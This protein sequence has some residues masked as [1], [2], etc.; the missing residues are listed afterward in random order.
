MK[1]VTRYETSESVTSWLSG[2]DELV[3]CVRAAQ[4]GSSRSEGSE[5][6]DPLSRSLLFLLEKSASH[7]IR[8]I[9]V[10]S[11]GSVVGV[12]YQLCYSR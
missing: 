11:L 3:P 1:N 9:S 8:V 12:V 5:D 6:I 2:C 10:F 4:R 7:K